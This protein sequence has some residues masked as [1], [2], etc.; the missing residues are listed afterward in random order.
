[1]SCASKPA[2][3]EVLEA[4]FVLVAPTNTNGIE[5]IDAATVERL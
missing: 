2:E 1:M 4:T 3:A 5:D